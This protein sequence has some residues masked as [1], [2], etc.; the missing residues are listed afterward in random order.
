MIGLPDLGA[1]STGARLLA[2][3]LV[4]FART[5]TGGCRRVVRDRSDK[6]KR[7]GERIN[8]ALVSRFRGAED[9]VGEFVKTS[10]LGM[11][12]LVTRSSPP[13]VQGLDLRRPTRS[14]ARLRRNS[15]CRIMRA[16]DSLTDP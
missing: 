13:D 12:G 14:A 1:W 2:G 10:K 7:T 16:I 9:V 4:R 8:E 15:S 11:R 5:A 6:A 3:D